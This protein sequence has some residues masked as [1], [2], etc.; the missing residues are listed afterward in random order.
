MNRILSCRAENDRQPW[1]LYEIVTR[2]LLPLVFSKKN[3]SKVVT[4]PL[5]A[6]PSVPLTSTEDTPDPQ[7]FSFN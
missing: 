2:K 7:H 4:M 1:S 5:S 3:S 6:M